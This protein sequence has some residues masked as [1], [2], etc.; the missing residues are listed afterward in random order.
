MNLYPIALFAHVVGALLL[1]A[2]LTLEGVAL[3]QARRAA[4]A[5]EA[6]SAMA[7]LRLNRMV[8]PL[9]AVGILVPGLFMMATLWGLVIWIA[10]ALAAWGLIAVG[11][12]VNGARML[13]LERKLARES[14]GVAT[15]T[16]AQL[17]D[18]FFPTTWLT[19]LG[20]A[21]GV[22]F[23]MTVKPGAAGSVT[24]IVIAATVGLAASLPVWSRARSQASGPH[25]AQEGQRT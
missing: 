8:G 9:S 1:F 6:R 16:A 10:V 18:P 23:L 17:R 25:A 11:G 21:L 22:V 2:S 19:R 13:A 5:E 24:A 4:S 20:M 3:R 15:A 14:G 12:A 7:I